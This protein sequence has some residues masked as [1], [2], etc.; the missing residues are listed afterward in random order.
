MSSSSEPQPPF[1]TQ[2]SSAGQ[3]FVSASV[4]LVTAVECVGARVQQLDAA[5]SDSANT[6][7]GLREHVAKVEQRVEII[8]HKPED[9]TKWAQLVLS[10]LALII[11]LISG[12]YSI[13]FGNAND[14][15]SRR[16]EALE[17][18]NSDEAAQETILTLI[19]SMVALEPQTHNPAG[20]VNPVSLSANSQFREEANRVEIYRANHGFTQVEAKMFASLMR[21]V[22]Q[23]PDI[24]HAKS[25]WSSVD[26]VKKSNLDDSLELALV[27]A[28]FA[29]RIDSKDEFDKAVSRLNS[30]LQDR[31]IRSDQQIDVLLALAQMYAGVVPIVGKNLDSA[32]DELRSVSG[33]LSTARTNEPDF[34]KDVDAR[35]DSVKASIKAA[36]DKLDAAEEKRRK[37]KQEREHPTQS[38]IPAIN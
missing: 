19:T 24:E 32:R 29:R 5:S 3:Q 8:E 26:Q 9:N 17:H 37:D 12:A 33:V 21:T 11:S 7:A 25:Y 15:L 27:D 34:G 31:K 13:K 23:Y 4:A 20:Q 35:V 6:I 36:Q 1:S 18:K 30:C 2:L 28:D 10:V 14:A 16:T 22:L 38:S